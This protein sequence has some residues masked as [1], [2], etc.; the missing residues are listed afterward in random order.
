VLAAAGGHVVLT[1]R[2]ELELAHVAADVPGSLVVAG[3]ITSEPDRQRLLDKT[4]QRFGRIDVL[5]NNAGTAV[6]APAADTPLEEF[7]AMI[8]TDLALRRAAR[9]EELDGTILFLASDASSFITGQH[10]LVDGGWSVY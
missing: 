6:S 5:V 2:R 10:L 1:A 9:L 8:E 3:D 4:F 7:R